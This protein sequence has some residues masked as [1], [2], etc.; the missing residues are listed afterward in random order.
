M[1]ILILK[2]YMQTFCIN[3]TTFGNRPKKIWN[4]YF[5]LEKKAYKQKKSIELANVVE[6]AGVSSKSF[7][8]S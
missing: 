6:I 2:R 4:Y 3:G 1:H 7:K 5:I 8:D